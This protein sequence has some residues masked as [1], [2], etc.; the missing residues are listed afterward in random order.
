MLL[1]NMGIDVIYELI[2]E[3][4]MSIKLEYIA[5]R[6]RIEKPLWKGAYGYLYTGIRMSYI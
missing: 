3:L 1:D 2:I 6:Y 4:M 5:K